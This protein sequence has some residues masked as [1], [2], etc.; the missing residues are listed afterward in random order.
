MVKSPQFRLHFIVFLWGFT[1]ILGKLISVDAVV[2][3]FY[4]TLFSAGFLYFFIRSIKKQSLR[5]SRRNLWQL[6]GT[7][8]II[9]FHW[10]AF[11]Y[12]IKI[13]NVSIALAC[14]SS[15]TLF[16]SLLEPLFFKRKID[17]LELIMG[18]V[19]VICISLIFNAQ[20]EYKW[21][22]I[23][24]II[25]AFLS[26]LF[27]VLNGKMFGKT[28]SENIIFYEILGGWLVVALFSLFSGDIGTLA[29]VSTR[30]FILIVVL[31]SLFTAFPMLESIRLMEFVS[32]FT[33]ALTVNL[34]PV[35]GIIIAFFIFGDSEH[36]S[37]IFYIA[38]FV[39]ILAIVING[40]VKAKRKKNTA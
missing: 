13:A 4:R 34:E 30:D 37:S 16:A 21:G 12:S 11:F 22:I 1:A 26:A 23:F 39:M 27:T 8:G 38:S 10:L 17:P 2:L 31:A 32:P 14:L 36:M 18:V 35:Y 15:A 25:C 5:I 9:G 20:F 19:I 33:L 7:G 29:Q 40:V 3:V 24:G 6:L 28:S